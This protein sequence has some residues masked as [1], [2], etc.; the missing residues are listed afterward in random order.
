MGPPDLISCLF[1]T[2]RSF[3]RRPS[4]LP[5][6]RWALQ[7]GPPKMALCPLTTCA[8]SPFNVE[9]HKLANYGQTFPNPVR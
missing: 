4:R 1:E 6:L 7:R 5:A 8:K 3:N 2:S 9:Q